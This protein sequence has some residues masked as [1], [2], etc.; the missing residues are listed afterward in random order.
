[1]NKHL[2]IFKAGKH[3]DAHGKVL[4]FSDD[5]LKTIVANYDPK[6]HE[7]PIVIGHPKADAPAYGWVGDL[8]TDGKLLAAVPTQ[9]D[10]QF[11]EL[12]E[13]GRYKKVS[14]SFYL[15]GAAGNPKPE[16]YYLRHVG[17]LGAQPPAIKGLKSAEFNEAED[18]VVEFSDFTTPGL[19]R[20]V[21]EFII[22]KFGRETAD[23][24]V[25]DWQ[26][27]SLRDKAVRDETVEQ[28][29]LSL[30]FSEAETDLGGTET[31][32]AQQSIKTNGEKTM[33]EQDK[34]RLADLEAENAQL[35]AA[36]AAEAKAKAEAEN[37]DFAEGLVND[38][39]L[40]PKHKDKLLDLLNADTATAD[41]AEDSFKDDLKAFLNDLPVVAD[42][43]ETATKDKV[44][45]VQD[46]SVEYAE[47]TDPER[48]ALDQKA[49]AYMT[50]HNCDYVTAVNAVA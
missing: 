7:A 41:F 45:D 38:G 40:L 6:L 35:K 39:K 27:N 46:E 50:Q 31:E 44:A 42:F 10:A 25:P 4:N 36:A 34:Q 12:V 16:G 11:A 13:Q 47:G 21:R 48:I 20:K 28:A 17:F 24:V 15:P 22:E 23:Q 9:V 19:F 37:A 33:S 49:R 26:V 43:S 5:D 18:G 14:A 1:M 8:S 32:D 29:E 30:N 3:T 2:E